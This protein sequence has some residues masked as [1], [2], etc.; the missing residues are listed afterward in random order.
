[1]IFRPCSF[2]DDPA[3][4]C[5]HGYLTEDHRSSLVDLSKLVFRQKGTWFFLVV[6]TLFDDVAISLKEASQ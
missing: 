1:M 6:I 3:L 5:V 2:A 4:L